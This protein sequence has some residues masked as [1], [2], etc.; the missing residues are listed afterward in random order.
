MRFRPLVASAGVV[1]LLASPA[2]AEEQ[3]RLVY[4]RE[5]NAADCPSEGALKEAVK[6]RMGYSP[7]FPLASTIASVELRY[8]DGKYIAKV[9][10]VDDGRVSGVRELS[11]T[12]CL[13]LVR[14]VAL[15]LS[16]AID[17]KAVERVE[18]AEA[19]PPPPPPAEPAPPSEVVVTVATKRAEATTG[20]KPEAPR[21]DA[22]RDRVSV[23]ASV[24]IAGNAGTA[25]SVSASG[26]GELRVAYRAWSVGLGARV[27]APS[28]IEA[29]TGAVV[30]AS[31]MGV[32]VAPCFRRAVFSACAVLLAGT[33]RASASRIS[34][35]GSDAELHLALGP[36]LRLTYP[37]SS[38]VEASG[39]G[40]L[41]GSFTPHTSFV[42]DVAVHRASRASVGLGVGI[43]VRLW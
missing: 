28:S 16:L 21:V 33:Y 10:T 19:T 35:P 14:T 24:A 4:V 40:E 5:E 15:S 20:P 38:R 31:V 12:T 6:A 42:D 7:F 18:R 17:P 39:Y 1:L 22:A 3:T 23:E 8:E 2:S 41:L 26:V 32:T 34:A 29:P 36:R 43:S 30:S 27:D 13:D 11:S 37:L 25:P 9:R